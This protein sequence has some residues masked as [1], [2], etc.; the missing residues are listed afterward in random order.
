MIRK[1]KHDRQKRSMAAQNPTVALEGKGNTWPTIW[2]RPRVDRSG[3]DDLDFTF[4]PPGRIPHRRW[5][6]REA[7]GSAHRPGQR[8][9]VDRSSGMERRSGKEG[10]QRS[11]A[12]DPPPCGLQHGDLDDEGHRKYGERTSQPDPVAEHAGEVRKHA[13]TDQEMPG[14]ASQTLLENI[15]ISDP[16]RATRTKARIRHAGR[17]RRSNRPSP[18]TRERPR[19]R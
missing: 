4:F 18:R 7:V 12:D 11:R 9:K 15:I 8:P 19:R 5:R 6:G 3:Q 1:D 10:R 14:P 13:A 17:K 2:K 16:A